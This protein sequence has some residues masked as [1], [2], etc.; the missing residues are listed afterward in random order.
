MQR[1]ELMSIQSVRE[2]KVRL[3]TQEMLG[4]SGGYFANSG[5]Y[6]TSVSGRSFN[7][8]LTPYGVVPGRVVWIDPRE[9]VVKVRVIRGDVPSKLRG[10]SCKYSRNRNVEV[11]NARNRGA[12][13]PFMEVAYDLIP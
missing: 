10:V 1:C 9:V 4:F 5:E 8:V 6:V 13:H 11:A 3:A 2:N 7:R 12:C